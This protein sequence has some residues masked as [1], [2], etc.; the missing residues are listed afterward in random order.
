MKNIAVVTGASS[1]MGAYCA[2]TVRNNVDVDEV[3]LIARSVDKLKETSKKINIDMKILPLDLT[4]EDDFR[5]YKRELKKEKVN[6][7]IL[8]NAAGYGIFD[9]VRNTRY[10]DNV[11]M[12]DL[13]C[14]G[15]TRMTIVSL[16]FM[17]EGSIIINFASLAGYMPI[18]YISIYAATKAYVLSF[19]RSL[20]RELANDGI[21]VM[22]VSPFWTKT[23]FFNRAVNKDHEVVKKYVCMYEP[24]KVVDKAWR[25]LK[26]NKECSSYGFMNNLNRILSKLLPHSLVMWIWMKQQKL[27]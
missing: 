7:K 12:I 20:R 23:N 1:G 13:N 17:S 26:K 25:D 3:W 22:A 16:P 14:T 5:K 8:I 9:S 11:G 24:N 27:K 2:L 4:V 21:K 15:L 6:I 10:R 18:P 19:T